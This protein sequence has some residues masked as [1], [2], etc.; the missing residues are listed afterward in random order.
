MDSFPAAVE[1]VYRSTAKHDRGLK[2]LVIK[3]M[4]AKLQTFNDKEKQAVNK[5]LEDIPEFSYDL[6][7]ALMMERQ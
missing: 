2:D 5:L 7:I 6:C 4:M 1:E 3:L